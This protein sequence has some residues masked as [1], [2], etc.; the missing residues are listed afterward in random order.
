MCDKE[1][2]SEAARLMHAECDDGGS[3]SVGRRQ[4]QATLDFPPVGKKRAKN[5]H[6]RTAA[7]P[8]VPG[9]I[10]VQSMSHA[11]RLREL[12]DQLEN[13]ELRRLVLSG[14][15]FHHAE[16]SVKD[17]ALISAAYKW[18]HFVS[19]CHNELSHGCESTAHL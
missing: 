18:G 12:S 9:G 19:M 11:R 2:S 15:A 6:Q 17:R 3:S 1:E 14:T 13:S 7:V 8:V 10:N 16:V 5:G 4:Q